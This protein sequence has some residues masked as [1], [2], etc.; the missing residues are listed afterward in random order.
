MKLLSYSYMR[1][2]P[3]YTI[4]EHIY[5]RSRT[6]AIPRVGIRGFYLRKLRIPVIWF[7]ESRPLTLSTGVVRWSPRLLV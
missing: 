7:V 2:D 5:R 3:S 4:A 1:V 6:P